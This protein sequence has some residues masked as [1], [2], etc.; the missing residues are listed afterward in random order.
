[1]LLVKERE[2]NKHILKASVLVVL[3]CFLLLIGYCGSLKGTIFHLIVCVLLYDSCR[4]IDSLQN[5]YETFLVM[6]SGREGREKDFF[7]FFL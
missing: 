1:M 3:F 2:A 5:S 6:R 7:F 4:H